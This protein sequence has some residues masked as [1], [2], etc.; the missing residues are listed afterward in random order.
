MKKSTPYSYCIFYIER[1]YSDRI[2]QE[3][4]EKGYDQLKA[5]IPT[6]NVLKKTIKG[7]MVFE[8]VPVLFNYGF[9][10]MPTEF[11]FSRPFLNKL[12]RNI[13]GIR[14][15]LKNTETMHQRKKKIKIDN[16]EDFD[17]FSLVATCS[18]KDVRRFKR[19]AK[20]NKKFS[21]DDLMNVSIGDYIV[22]K[23]YPY[24]GIDATVLE[25]DYIN[26]MVKMLLYP[27][28]GRMEIWLPF[29]N[30]IY[31]VYQNYDPDKL[32]ANSQEFDPNQ[33]TCE[34][35]NRVLNIKSRKRK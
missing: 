22:L 11:A 4:K 7:K 12:K 27:E 3:L 29:D 16:P 30:V 21:V 24:E 17:D 35:I 23:G 19:M 31:S 9:M 20:E 6:V 8:E 32:Y 14:T 25:V 5:I 1:K 13:S 2:N 28:M 18:R 10:R 34:Q 33:I 15:W 26:K